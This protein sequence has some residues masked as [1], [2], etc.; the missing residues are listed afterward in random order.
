MKESIY[1]LTVN[2]ADGQ[3]VKMAEY[4]GKVL[5]LVNVASQC[6]FTPQYEGLEKLHREYKDRGLTV[7]AF[8]SNDFGGQEPG[9]MEEIMTFCR[10]RYDVTF[11]VMEK[12][13]AIGEQKHP[14]YQWLTDASE[15]GEEVKWNFEKFLISRDGQLLA[16]YD[17]RTSPEDPVLLSDVEKAL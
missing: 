2:R 10:T 7:L 8:P 12:V 15:S 11:E 14:L 16:R 6:G 17:S 5:L 1:D 13:H 4:K 3:P 9:T